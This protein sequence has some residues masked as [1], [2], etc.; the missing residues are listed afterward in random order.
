M[1]ENKSDK[2]NIMKIDEDR[3]VYILGF[4]HWENR[5]CPMFARRKIASTISYQHCLILLIGFG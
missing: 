5:Q 2:T 4:W 3:F 1:V